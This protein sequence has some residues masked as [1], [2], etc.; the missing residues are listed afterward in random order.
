M[1]FI[2]LLLAVFLTLLSITQLVGQWVLAGEFRPYM[3]LLIVMVLL[4]GVF[5]HQAWKEW[6]DTRTNK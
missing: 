2:Q 3:V 1:A 6:Q 5:V 4:C